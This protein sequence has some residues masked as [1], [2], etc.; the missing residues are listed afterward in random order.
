MQAAAGTKSCRV[1]GLSGCQSDGAH[2]TQHP[3][4]IQ[5]HLAL[6]HALRRGLRQQPAAWPAQLRFPLVCQR[7]PLLHIRRRAQASGG[8]LVQLA[9]CMQTSEEQGATCLA[10]RVQARVKLRPSVR[11]RICFIL[12]RILVTWSSTYVSR[13]SVEWLRSASCAVRTRTCM[14][15]EPVSM[16]MLRPVHIRSFL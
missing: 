8:G 16:T 13:P 3:D 11:T 4:L 6:R 14:A 10:A 9:D 15:R 5:A 1:A 7:E 2:V 12:E